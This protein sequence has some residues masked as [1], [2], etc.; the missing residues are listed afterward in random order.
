MRTRFCKGFNSVRSLRFLREPL[1]MS[2]RNGARNWHH[3]FG[4]DDPNYG[5]VF[6]AVADEL[7]AN[8]QV[9]H[10]EDGYYVI[11]RYEDIVNVLRDWKT[12]PSADGIIGA[13][14]APEQP[15]FKQT[16]PI[17]L[18]TPNSGERWPGS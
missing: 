12:F 8:C 6:N 2:I 14:R 5:N 1:F 15:L 9:A 11:S 7:V 4:L 17:R 10:S 16:R 18:S 13:V 3:D